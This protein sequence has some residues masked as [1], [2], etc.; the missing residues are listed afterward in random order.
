M[1]TARSGGCRVATLIAGL[2]LA[3]T[4]CS[5]HA[6]TEDDL[7]Q[8]LTEAHSA[9]GAS[10]LALDQLDRGRTTRAAAQ[11]ALEDMSKQV[12]D[13]QHAIDPIKIG[14]DAEREDRD[15]T[16][17][18]LAGGA[19]ATLNARDE[20]ALHD[21]S[22]SRDEL[23][24]AD[25]VVTTPA[26]SASGGRVKKVLG[27][28]LGVLTAIG[29]F[30]DIGDLVTNA[31]VGSRFGLSLALGGRRRCGGN[32]HLRADV[33]PGGC[34]E[35]PGDLRAD[36]GAVGSAGGAGEPRCLVLDQLDD[37]DR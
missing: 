12:S 23:I 19:A 37:P 10:V 29:G 4:G 2:L 17:A 9:L 1:S 30:L 6:A 8:A 36:P 20:L 5:Q 11:T 16:S 21:R 31:V 26:G 32:L 24:A 18:A 3:L 13:A 15:A 22:V 25:A 14:N 33:G 28:A 27:L 7:M 34:R 35:W